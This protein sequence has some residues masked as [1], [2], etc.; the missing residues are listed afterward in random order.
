MRRVKK[1]WQ[2]KCGVLVECVEKQNLS[3][4]DRE[5]IMVLI[6]IEDHNRQVIEAIAANKACNNPS[7]FDWQSQLR[8]EKSE[9]IDT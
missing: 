5:K 1:M 7:H 6:I 4:R 8:F 3:R 9:A 2:Q